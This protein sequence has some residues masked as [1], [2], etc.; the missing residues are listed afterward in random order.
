MIDGTVT[1][2]SYTGTVLFRMSRSGRS[3][4][5]TVFWLL[6]VVRRVRK[7]YNVCAVDIH[8]GL[9]GKHR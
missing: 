3:I 4:T 8:L 2:L 1:A 5:N 6:R 9:H 7:R